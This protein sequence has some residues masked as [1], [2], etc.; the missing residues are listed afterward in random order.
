MEKCNGKAISVI[1][2]FSKEKEESL[3]ILL[4]SQVLSPF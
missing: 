3:D 1:R 4:Q 2:G